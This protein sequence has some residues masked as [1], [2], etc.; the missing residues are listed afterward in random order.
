MI[1][2]NRLGEQW[3]SY[4]REVMNPS[5]SAR[6]KAET[7]LAFYGGAGALMAIVFAGLTPGPDSTPADEMFLLELQA[8]LKEFREQ[9][10]RGA[11]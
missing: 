6:Q 2:R 9:V 8:E 1:R 11:A 10:K 7:R 4:V 5:A 3:D